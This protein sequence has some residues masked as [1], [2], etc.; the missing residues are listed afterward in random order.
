ML[1]K[2]ISTLSM[3]ALS[4]GMCLQGQDTQNEI[5]CG[6]K[7]AASA[8]QGF[9]EDWSQGI[10]PQRWYLLRKVWGAGNN[11]CVPE[12]VSVQSDAVDGVTK[13]VVVVT[14]QGNQTTSSIMGVKKVGGGYVKG[15]SPKRVGGCLATVD[16]FASGTYE[17]KMKVGRPK[18]APNAAPKGL[19]PAIWTF[20]YEE[21]YPSA[22][23]PKGVA[24]NPKDPLYQPRFKE[25]SDADGYYSTVNSE[26]DA[27]ELGKGGNLNLGLYTTYVSEVVANTQGFDLTKFGINVL[28]NKYHTYKFVWK[29]K[30]Q[31]T[32]LTDKQVI[33]KNGYYYVANNA[34]SPIQGFPAIKKADG[35]WY[36]YKGASV[37]FY[38][39]GK[40]VGKSTSNVSPVSARLLVGGWFPSWAGT[41]NWDETKLYISD[42]TITPSNDPGDVFFQPESYP[43]DGMV[44]P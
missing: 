42:I 35:I 3:L 26:I 20:H 4:L 2:Y 32:A 28:D 29:T 41:P 33:L 8:P 44:S 5:I 23:D 27:P 12:L 21:H 25:G 1:A 9:H 38:V 30:L 40:L 17:I 10:S 18:N 14:N 15:T 19:C 43:L 39:D 36:V 7:N 13:N 24:I 31:S 11:G 37:T 34:T 16:Y 22:N 6:A